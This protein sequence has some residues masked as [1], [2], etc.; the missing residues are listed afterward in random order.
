MPR[1]TAAAASS[2]GCAAPA[3]SAGPTV[4]DPERGE[5][6]DAVGDALFSP[7]ASPAS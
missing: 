7:S 3:A 2:S 1:S 6:F 4:A 5:L